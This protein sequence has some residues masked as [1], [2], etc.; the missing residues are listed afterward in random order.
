MLKKTSTLV[1]SA[2]LLATSPAHAEGWLDSIKAFLGLGEQQSQQQEQQV[3]QQTAN[4][5]GLINSL[6]SLG[7]TDGQI[8]GGL[9]AIFNFVKTSVSSGDFKQLTDA[10]PGS[11]QLLNSVPDTSQIKSDSGLSGLLDKA[12]E[13]SESVKAVNDLKKQF[14]ALGLSPEMIGQYGTKIQNYLNTPEGAE[15]KK[16]LQDSL[17]KL[18]G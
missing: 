14:E 15:A 1:L 6:K 13:Y 3:E 16:V 9:A 7:V 8:E 11:E 10:L 17:G 12:S 5:Q 2:S 4:L 18:L